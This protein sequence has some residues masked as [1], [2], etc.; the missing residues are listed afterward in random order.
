[1]KPEYRKSGDQIQISLII[2]DTVQYKL[3]NVSL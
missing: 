1:M 2:D 3:Q